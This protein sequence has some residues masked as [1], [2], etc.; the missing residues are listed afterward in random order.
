MSKIKYGGLDQYGNVW[1]LSGVGGQGLSVTPYVLNFYVLLWISRDPWYR[2]C[3]NN[4]NNKA[5]CPIGNINPRA[6]AAN[7]TNK[8]LE[9]TKIA[10]KLEGQCQHIFLYTCIKL[11]IFWRVVLGVFT[12]TGRHTDGQTYRQTPVKTIRASPAWLVYRCWSVR[13]FPL[14]KMICP[15]MRLRQFK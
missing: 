9:S 8:I 15:Q 3:K 5:A 14:H 10:R 12:R 7:A 4:N 1:S 13:P 2:G 11:H 6:A